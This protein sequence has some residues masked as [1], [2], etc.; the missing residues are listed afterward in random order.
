MNR[1]D[2]MRVLKFDMDDLSKNRDGDI[3]DKQRQLNAPP[4][5]SKLVYIVILVHL[6]LIGGILGAI[7]LFTGETALWIVFFIVMGLG[8]MPFVVL[9]NEGNVRPLLR[10]D[11]ENGRVKSTSGIAILEA[12]KGRYPYFLLTIDGITM[13]LNKTQATVFKH[14]E[15]YCAY[16]LP[17][18]KTLVSAEPINAN[19]LLAASGE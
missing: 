8:A 6:A 19:E 2:M 4:E 18:S 17:L 9:Q 3:S 13:K 11:I 16:Y 1:I 15:T 10:G 5:I 12:R 7:A 14:G